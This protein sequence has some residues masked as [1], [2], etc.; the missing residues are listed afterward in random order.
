LFPLRGPFPHTAHDAAMIVSSEW[1]V[2]NQASKS[3]GRRKVGQ[4]E[5][6]G[7][8]VDTASGGK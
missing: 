3:S 6:A 8:V 2:V 4:A 1:I 7:A 5:A